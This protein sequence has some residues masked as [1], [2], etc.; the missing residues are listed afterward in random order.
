MQ[1]AECFGD[2]LRTCSGSGALPEDTTCTWGCGCAH[3]LQIVP[4]GGAVMPGDVG[5]GSD[6]LVDQTLGS[7]N[8]EITVINGQD[9]SIKVGSTMVR[10]AG[11]GIIAGIDYEQRGSNA[12]VFRMKSLTITGMTYLRGN[13][14]IAIVATT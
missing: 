4:A 1:S 5:L 12:A 11:L 6:A 3:C 7:G 2:V 8:G 10:G 14:A 9:G 13:R